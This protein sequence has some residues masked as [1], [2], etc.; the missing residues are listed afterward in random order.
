[1][2]SNRYKEACHLPEKLGKNISLLILSNFECVFRTA[3]PENRITVFSHLASDDSNWWYNFDLEKIFTTYT[4]LFVKK[5]NDIENQ[6]AEYF[7]KNGKEKKYDAITFQ[8][9]RSEL[10]LQVRKLLTKFEENLK[11]KVLLFFKDFQK[12]GAESP[13]RI[14]GSWLKR[15]NSVV[16]EADYFHILGINY[17]TYF[18]KLLT[19]LTKI[20]KS[21]PFYH[22]NIKKFLINKI[23]KINPSLFDEDKL[24]YELD[25]L[26]K[27]SKAGMQEERLYGVQRVK[28]FLM[29]SGLQTLIPFEHMPIASSLG[30]EFYRVELPIRQNANLEKYAPYGRYSVYQVLDRTETARKSNFNKILTDFRLSFDKEN[31]FDFFTEKKGDEKIGQNCYYIVNPDGSLKSIEDKLKP[32]LNRQLSWKGVMGTPPTSTQVAEYLKKGY[33]LM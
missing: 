20:E 32:I 4:V 8:K 25:N 33:H 13:E 28:N 3:D 7:G 16:G 29:V 24:L 2:P 27:P 19:L 6:M 18:S 22:E 31:S 12:I 5:K 23:K 30:T 14:R 1:M 11:E 26:K 15:R 21:N 10:N 9:K 17:M